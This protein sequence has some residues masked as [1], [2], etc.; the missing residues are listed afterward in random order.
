MYVEEEKTFLSLIIDEVQK[1]P[2]VSKEWWEELIQ[3]RANIIHLYI[4]EQILYGKLWHQ[5]SALVQIMHYI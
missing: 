5:L 2:E 1:V 3:G 4:L